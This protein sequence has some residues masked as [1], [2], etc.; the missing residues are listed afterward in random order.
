[1]A[2]LCYSLMGAALL[3]ANIALA[4]QPEAP[5][6]EDRITTAATEHRLRLDF[7]NGLF[8]GPAWD[9]LL[10]E[11]RNAQFFLVG[12]EHGI[13]ENPLLV[14]QLFTALSEHGYEKLAIEVSPTM[15]WILDQALEQDGLNGL[16]ELFSR[17][18]G[19]PAFFGMAQE[20]EMLAIVRAAAPDG[21]LV[22]WGT[23]YEVAGDRQLLRRLEQAD[24]PAAAEAALDDLVAASAASWAKYRETRSPQYI[25]SFA[26][27][28]AL[29]RAVREAWPEPDSWSAVILNTLEKTLT[30]NNLWVQGRAW[31]SNA[32]RADLQRANFL[33]YWRAEKARGSVPKVMAKYG[34]SHMVQGLSQT[35]VYDLGTLLPA[36]A[37]LEGSHSFSVM[38]VPGKDSMIA[39]LNP[40]TWSYEPRPAQAGYLDGIAPLTQA[41]F[42]NTFTLIDLVALRPVVGMNRG[43]LDDELFRIVH[44]FD[45]LLVMSGSTPS[46]ELIHDAPDP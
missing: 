33:R 22:L 46:S 20:A 9:R 27:D 19:E 23:D 16:R 40:S 6:V 21:R 5:S 14:A 11:G 34:A 4:D 28:P 8:F 35:A 36:L 30:V 2:R 41:A 42:D 29:V 15:A 31:E 25:F 18:G 24:K 39:G 43:D 37:E 17:P 44:G 45:M 1:M 38:V 10:A 12:E 26:G 13:A 7:G 3:V 32:V